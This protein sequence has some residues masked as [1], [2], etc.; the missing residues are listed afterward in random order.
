MLQIFNNFRTGEVEL[1]E[2]PTPKVSEKFVLSHTRCSL[3]SAGTE[4]MLIDFAKS[5]YLAKA[6][7]QPQK[8]IQVVNKIKTDGLVDTINAVGSQ[9]N[10]PIPMG[11]SNVGVVLESKSVRFKVGDRIVSNGPHA[12][13][14]AVN[15]NLAAKIPDNVSDEEASFSVLGAIALQGLRLAEP[16]LGEKF[17]VIGCGLVGL[18]AVQLLRSNGCD[19]VAIEPNAKRTSLAINF[20]AKAPSDISDEK[21]IA[22]CENLTDGNGL[23]GVIICAS[24]SKSDVI[25]LAARLCRKRGRII[26]V[27]V[28]GLNLDRN[29]FYDKELLFQV[30][31][32]YGPG[33]YEQ[34]YEVL[35]ND[36]PYAFVR[37]TEQRNIQTVLDL[38]SQNKIDVKSLIDE[39]F[40]I[41]DAAAAYSIL[42]SQKETNGII[43][44]YSASKAQRRVGKVFSKTDSGKFSENNKFN[45]GVIGAGRYAQFLVPIFLKH[46]F[47][48]SGIYAP[49]GVNAFDLQ[50]KSKA[51]YITTD[52]DTVFNDPNIGTIVV[53]STHDDHCRSIVSALRM[54]KNDYVEKQAEIIRTIT[55]GEINTL[56]RKYLNLDNAYILVVGDAAAHRDKLKALGYEVIDVSPKGD[57]LD[58]I[59]EG[60]GDTEH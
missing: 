34:D 26:S 49:S 29:L 57:V 9:L 23:D 37:F 15:H 12:E 27:G 44:R 45:L 6:K 3:I 41:Q 18:L 21:V 7:K 53:L 13:Q 24:A 48:V 51:K 2:L 55:P 17:A 54:D 8:V 35:G 30:S 20:G 46:G 31:C 25:Q 38:L 40:E 52:K 39:Y 36:Y 22:Y 33:R 11:Y 5:S 1:K 32:S 42:L 43:L 14:V 28:T 59:Q 4:R 19:V 50:N 58:E 10:K 60:T 47:C 56:A 16:K